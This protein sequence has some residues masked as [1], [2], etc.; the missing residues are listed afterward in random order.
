VP[1]RCL[2]CGKTFKTRG[3]RNQHLT[4]KQHWSR[5]KDAKPG[6][7][8]LRRRSTDS[9]ARQRSARRDGAATDTPAREAPRRTERHD[10]DVAV[11][12]ARG[13]AIVV[14]WPQV[15]GATRLRIEVL[16]AAG[17]RVRRARVGSE[18]GEIRIG[19]LTQFRQPL[20]VVV[21]I[22]GIG[23]VP[24]TSGRVAIDVGA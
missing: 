19:K 3:A 4:D 14:S 24:L 20:T 13:G 1:S 16:D 9:A 22:R 5:T 7:R 21:V 6:A 2:I 18:L 15:S 12:S 10:G 11:R 8:P 17:L 23:G